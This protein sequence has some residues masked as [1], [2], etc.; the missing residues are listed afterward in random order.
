MRTNRPR[1]LGPPLRA[2]PT[3]IRKLLAAS[4][5]WSSAPHAPSRLSAAQTGRGRKAL[6]STCSA[7]RARA[8]RQRHACSSQPAETGSRAVG[9][10]VR[11]RLQ[12]P[13]PSQQLAEAGLVE[14][15]T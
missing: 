2:T 12:R 5:V 15:G 13:A 6:L 3:P 11:L 8:R 4:T 7:P 9:A 10:P 14:I 1:A